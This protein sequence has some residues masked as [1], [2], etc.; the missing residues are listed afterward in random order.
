VPSA[1]TAE[2]IND[3]LG[4]THVFASSVNN[5]IEKRLLREVGPRQLTSS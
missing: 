3:F 5:V 4:S 2:L 1:C